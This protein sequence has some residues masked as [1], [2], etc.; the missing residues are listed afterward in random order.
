MIQIIPASPAHIGPLANRMREIDRL[1]CSIYG[2]TPKQSLRLALKSSVIAWT[3]KVDGRVEAMFGASPISTLEGIG[4]PWMLMTDEATRHAKA[5]VAG[6]LGY[7]VALQALFPVLE[8]NVHADN[9]TAIRWLSRLGY[10]IG[11]VFDM[12][13]YPM[14]KFR[15]EGV[16]CASQQPC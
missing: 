15:R 12:G 7:S 14:R 6:G 2:R 5:L 16:S 3:A 13:G 10:T 11:P 4:C 8:N 1:E 9:H